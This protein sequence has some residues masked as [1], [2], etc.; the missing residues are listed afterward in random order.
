MPNPRL[1]LMCVLAAALC[2]VSHAKSTELEG[3]WSGEAPYARSV[4]WLRAMPI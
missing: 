2:A 3:G 1:A 4:W